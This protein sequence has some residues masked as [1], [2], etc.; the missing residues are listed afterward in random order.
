MSD[1]VRE[2]AFEP[3]FT[4]K[5]AG[6]GTGLGLSLCRSIAHDH[7][8]HIMLESA[9]GQGTRVSVWIPLDA[10]GAATLAK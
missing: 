10:S 9:A 1:A 6:R 2:R 3:L 7:G 8:G 4:T 5:P